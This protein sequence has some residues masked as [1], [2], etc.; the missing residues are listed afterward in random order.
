MIQKILMRTAA[1]LAA[2]IGAKAI[3]SF[4]EPYPF[5]SEIPVIWVQDLHIDVLK[6][7][8]M[9]D[10]FE[11]SE[12][13]LL[14]AAVQI[15]LSRRFEEGQV[16]GVLP[17]AILIYDIKQARNFINI[18]EYEDIVPRDI[19]FA[20]ISLATEIGV[21][22]REGRPVGT[23]FIIGDAD[24]IF[25]HSHQG[26]LNP[27]LGQKPEDC[28][29]K[30]R[31]NWESIKEFSLLDGVFVVDINGII[32]AAGRYLDMDGGCIRMPAGLGGRHRAAAAI[33]SK[34]PV[35]GVTLS[36]S[37]GIVRVFRDG[38]CKLSINSD[39]RIVRHDQ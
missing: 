2:H 7:L 11:V 4:A 27:F 14:D 12:R 8:T 38:E 19:I 6:E 3:V 31:D 33:T 28:D 34:L 5:D 16:V 37:G 1:D 25:A 18:R 17:Y 13:H 36:E 35:I 21:Q 29:I 9:Q 26:I 32:R 22:G 23:A 10:I 39:L 20:A 30:N 15:Y 24:E